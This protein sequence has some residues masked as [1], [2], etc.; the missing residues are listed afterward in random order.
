MVVNLAKTKEIL[1]HRPP[2]RS[3]LPAAI[4]GFEQNGLCY[5]T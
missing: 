3:S 1:F 2:V 4:T 5:V